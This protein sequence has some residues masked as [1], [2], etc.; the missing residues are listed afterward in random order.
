MSAARAASRASP[1]AGDDIP[2]LDIDDLPLRAEHRGDPLVMRFVELCDRAMRAEKV[3]DPAD[4]TPAERAAY[5][6]D[7]WEAFSRLRGYTED[8]IADFRAYLE[9]AADVATRYGIDTA[10]SI[11]YL[12]QK[13]VESS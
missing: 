12:V 2:E 1:R 8:E 6:G 4:W 10:C 7:D 9:A 5:G 3:S 13:H 11:A